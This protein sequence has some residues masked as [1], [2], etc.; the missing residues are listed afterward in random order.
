MG[1][2][3]LAERAD[4]AYAGQAAIKVVRAGRSSASVLA[5]FAVEQQ[6][7]ARLSHPHIA[8]LLDAGRTADGQPYFVMERVSG[9]PI[10][11]ACEGRPC[12]SGWASSCS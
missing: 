3:W 4:G 9:R 8:H 6:A 10:D 7:L 5:R 11:A 2:V 1:E 12:L